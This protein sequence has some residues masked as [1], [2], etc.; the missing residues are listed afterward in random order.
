MSDIGNKTNEVSLFSSLYSGSASLGLF[1]AEIGL[2]VGLVLSVM[3][4]LVGLHK[5]MY[6]DGMYLEVVG[7]VIKNLVK[8][9]DGSDSGPYYVYNVTYNVGNTRYNKQLFT[10]PQSA[11]QY[12]NNGEPISLWIDK[13]DHNN[14]TLAGYNGFTFISL[15]L[16]VVGISYF[17]YYLTRRFKFYAAGK[18]V[19]TIFNLF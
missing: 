6:E 7:K 18:G 2:I 17:N 16:L 1:M 9:N 11:K 14:V 10:K 8:D 15:A 12:M 19:S 13:Y 5:L 4:L 3:L